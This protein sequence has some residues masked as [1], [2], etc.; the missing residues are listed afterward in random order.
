MADGGKE[1]GSQAGEGPQGG[2]WAVRK[3]MA[4]LLTRA[5]QFQGT[6]FRVWGFDY[7][8]GL[9]LSGPQC[10]PQLSGKKSDL[11]GHCEGLRELT[12]AV[13]LAHRTCTRELF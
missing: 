9:D 3:E 6:Q 10:P 1:E 4:H 7:L 11:V 2:G 12:E 5:P 13:C 8:C